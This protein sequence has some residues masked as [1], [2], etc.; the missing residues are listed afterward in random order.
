M[1]VDVP[2]VVTGRKIRVLVVDDSA[3]MR[4]AIVN[5]LSS[6]PAIEVIGT[7][8][9]GQDGVDQ[10]LE[11]KPDL[12]TLDV[13]MPRMNG[14]EA[15][16][17]IMEKWPV[18]VLMLSSL[19]EEG[20]QATLEALDLG[21]VDFLPKS[22]DS[23]SINIVK[24]QRELIE[25]VKAI[26]GRKLVLRSR[27]DNGSGPHV[28]A[29]PTLT[30]K[31]HALDALH[32][33]RI[34]AIGTSTGGPKALQDVLPQLPKDFPV[35]IV[36]VQHM[37]KAFTGPFAAR[38]DTLC[39]IRV[40]EG[41]AHDKVEAG[42]AIIAPGGVHMKISRLGATGVEVVLTDQ[43]ADLLHKPSADVM[44]ASVAEAYGGAGLGVILTGMGADG[45]DG[46]AALKK[47]GGKVL[48]QDE[49]SCVVYGMPRAVVEA[50]L[51]DK[52]VPLDHMAGEIMNMV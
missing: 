42:T 40:R 25:K 16:R 1:I 43:P 37:P 46:I 20:A 29:V 39:Q 4:K 24:I 45:R 9:D 52:V 26:A 8:R 10:V 35:G 49:A 14:L 22:L 38:L 36:I 15:L 47:A 12:V 31:P 21:A 19:T 7:A 33:V 50:G 6:D 13:E 30:A 11:K 23:L 48:A 44:I 28:S 34:V 17:V 3:F 27:R 51:A 41:Q 18:P 2:P 32:R 5:M